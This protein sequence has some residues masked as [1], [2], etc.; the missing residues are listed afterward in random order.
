MQCGM[1]NEKEEVSIKMVRQSLD[2]KSLQVEQLMRKM[3]RYIEGNGGAGPDSRARRRMMGRKPR[4]QQ[5][6]STLQPKK[7]AHGHMTA[8]LQPRQ[9]VSPDKKKDVAVSTPGNCTQKNIGKK[10]TVVLPNEEDL[11]ERDGEVSK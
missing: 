5:M 2:A 10:V 6:C 9:S 1:S 7:T 4:L 11:E 8:S 3:N